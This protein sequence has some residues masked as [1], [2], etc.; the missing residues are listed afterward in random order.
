MK[1]YASI[2]DV[3]LELT[4]YK[5]ITDGYDVFNDRINTISDIL[6]LF[7]VKWRYKEIN[8]RFIAELL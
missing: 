8:G 5:N 7:D 3:M 6:L 2:N 4:R 1:K